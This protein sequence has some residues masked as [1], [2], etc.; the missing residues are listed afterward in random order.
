MGKISITLSFS[1]YFNEKKD[2]NIPIIKIDFENA[3]VYRSPSIIV[4][5]NQ[6][7]SKKTLSYKNRELTFTANVFSAEFTDECLWTKSKDN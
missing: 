4:K 2:A 3:L 1:N 7:A 6:A 5:K